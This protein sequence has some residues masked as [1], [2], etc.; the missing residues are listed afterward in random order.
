MNIATNIY[1]LVL[2]VSQIICIQHHILF[3]KY[4]NKCLIK[5]IKSF[6]IFHFEYVHI[7]VHFKNSRE[8]FQDSLNLLESN[9]YQYKCLLY[10]TYNY[11]T[12]IFFFNLLKL[13]KYGDELQWCMQLLEQKNNK[14][15]KKLLHQSHQQHLPLYSE[16]KIHA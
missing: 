15:L 11:F 14:N 3:P 13:K 9:Q 12:Q 5:T 8:K 4:C 2:Y 1:L 6:I 16:R 7:R 10:K